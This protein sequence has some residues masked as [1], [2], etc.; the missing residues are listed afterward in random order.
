MGPGLPHHDEETR[1]EYIAQLWA[2]AFLVAI[3]LACAA[4]IGLVVGTALFLLAFLF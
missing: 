4:V 3:L 1:T 2:L